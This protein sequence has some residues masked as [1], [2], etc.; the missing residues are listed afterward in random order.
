[1]SPFN[2]PRQHTRNARAGQSRSILAGHPRYPPRPLQNAGPRH[3]HRHRIRRTSA[4]TEFGCCP[5]TNARH[6]YDYWTTYCATTRKQTRRAPARDRS[7]RP[8]ELVRQLPLVTATRADGP[9]LKN[10]NL[11]LRARRC[12]VR[13]TGGEGVVSLR[14]E[15]ACVPTCRFID[16]SDTNV[17][18]RGSS[19]R[20]NLTQAAGQ[21]RRRA[22]KGFDLALSQARYLFRR[23]PP[24]GGTWRGL[25]TPRTPLPSRE[26]LP[27]RATRPIHSQR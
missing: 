10:G 16:G 4:R 13:S 12:A 27:F 8:D 23:S 11:H 18:T 24:L 17:S 19:A 7:R 3:R 5:A 6:Y 9:A 1:V 21:A 14:R 20:S 22:S 25:E 26:L 15:P 2:R